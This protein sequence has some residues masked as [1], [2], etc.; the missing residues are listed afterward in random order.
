MGLPTILI[1][2][3]NAGSPN[4]TNEGKATKILKKLIYILL[5]Y[6]GPSDIVTFYDRHFNPFKLT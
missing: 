3:N 4:K 5:F 1:L 2:I 6:I